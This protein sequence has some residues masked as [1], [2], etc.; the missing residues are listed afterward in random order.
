MDSRFEITIVLSLILAIVTVVFAYRKKG[1]KQDPLFGNCDSFVDKVAA[2]VFSAFFVAWPH[3]YL[4]GFVEVGLLAD[5]GINDWWL[6][7][8][9]ISTYNHIRF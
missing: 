7:Y 4:A 1:K 8:Y 6:D 3:L 5:L 9:P 2:V